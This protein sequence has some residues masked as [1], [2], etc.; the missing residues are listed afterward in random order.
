MT[1]TATVAGAPAGSRPVRVPVEPESGG[2]GAVGPGL[3]RRVLVMALIGGILWLGYFSAALSRRV[4]VVG[5]HE[6]APGR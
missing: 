1:A 2:R 6:L 5:T 3:P 4:K